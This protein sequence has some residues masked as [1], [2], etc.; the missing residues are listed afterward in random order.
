VQNRSGA[1]LFSLAFF[2]LASLSALEAFITERI[3][4]TQ[5]GSGKYY[6]TLSYYLPKITLDAL[7]LRILPA[8][9]YTL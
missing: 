8:V 3:I 9:A 4:F 6:R 5:E 7:F 1:F 2:S